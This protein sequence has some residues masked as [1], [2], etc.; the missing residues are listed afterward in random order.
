MLIKLTCSTCLYNALY[1][2]RGYTEYFRLCGIRED[3]V[4]ELI[5]PKGHQTTIVLQ[6]PKHE[7]LFTIAAHAI[8]DGYLREAIASF[9]ASLERFYEFA[10]RVICRA[11]STFPEDFEE[12]F[13]KY[14]KLVKN[15]SER[16]L[17]SFA[18]LWFVEMQEPP[19][20]LSSND[21]VVRNNVIHKGVIPT[22]KDCIGF[23]Q[24]VIN[25]VKPLD[26]KIRKKF[27]DAY[28]DEVQK[29][30]KLAREKGQVEKVL[31]IAS[32]FEA[33]VLNDKDLETCLE[34]L[35]QFREHQGI[36]ST[37]TDAWLAR[38]IIFYNP[39]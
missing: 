7:V 39:S 27:P 13:D 34:T 30:V 14:W 29:S 2:N 36:L 3:G 17:D 20:I 18:L 4:Y 5:C 23:G 32:T 28:R 33:T 11:R 24:S 1:E 38:E 21:T 26:S 16:Q 19:I 25:V 12:N 15:Q 9:A 35:K 22:Y 37:N 8:L 31:N 10:I 6:T